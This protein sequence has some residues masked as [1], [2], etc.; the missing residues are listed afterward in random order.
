VKREE[1][2]RRGEEERRTKKKE[3]RG[4]E[5]ELSVDLYVNTQVLLH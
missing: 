4:I 2:I 1:R 5:E 3:L